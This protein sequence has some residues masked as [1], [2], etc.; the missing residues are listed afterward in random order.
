MAKNVFCIAC[1]DHF[2]KV[3]HHHAIGDVPDD[4]QVVGYE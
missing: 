3:H 2:S 1:F 4:I